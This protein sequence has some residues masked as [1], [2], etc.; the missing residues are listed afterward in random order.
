MLKFT[1][2][3]LLIHRKCKCFVSDKQLDLNYRVQQLYIILNESPTCTL[4]QNQKAL[5]RAASCAM[6]II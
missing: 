6:Y 3:D 4:T 1:L 5:K 2:N